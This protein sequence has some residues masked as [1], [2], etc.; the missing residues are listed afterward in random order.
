MEN[1]GL[2]GIR[3]SNRDFTQKN[4]WGKN[5]FNS[6]FPA[7][8]ACYMSSKQLKANY[9]YSTV[10]KGYPGHHRDPVPI[11]KDLRSLTTYERARLQTFPKEYHWIG[12]KTEIEL[13]LGNAVPVK[14]AEFIA[15]RIL[16]FNQKSR[17][18]YTQLELNL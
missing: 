13:M 6:S 8:L 9:I 18:F 2:F 15:N 10:P 12:T 5:Q 11:T 4:S 1:P 7:A 14:L 3:Y 16:E 17:K